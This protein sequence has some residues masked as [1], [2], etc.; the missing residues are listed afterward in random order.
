[1]VPDLILKTPRL[2]LVLQSPAEVMVWL[3]TLPP[4]V[5]VEVS[6]VW[7]A[8]VQRATPGDFWS[9]SF[10]IRE[11]AT[12]QT[13]GGCAFKGPPNTLGCVEIA[14]GIDEPFRSRGFAT[15]AAQA[16]ADF[17]FQQPIVQQ[18]IAHTKTDNLTSGRVLAK[19]GFIERGTV[20]D[21]EDRLV[22]LWVLQR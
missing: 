16:L 2:E 4:E 6:P 14:Y 8:A 17:A 10:T 7:I 15:E 3:D 22:Q 1:V 9:L 19:C 11:T 18:V 5:R 13:V 20:E 21:P 12:A